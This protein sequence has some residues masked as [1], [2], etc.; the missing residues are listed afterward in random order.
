MKSK[1]WIIYMHTNLINGK[2]YVGQTHQ[3]I[4]T[5]GEIRGLDTKDNVFIKLYK[6]TVGIILS[7]KY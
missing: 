4:K 7:M 6:N 1:I 2:K 5:D 3:G